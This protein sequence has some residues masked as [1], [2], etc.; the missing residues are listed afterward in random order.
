MLCVCECVFFGI[1]RCK[2]ILNNLSSGKIHVASRRYTTVPAPC[3]GGNN[4]KSRSV[5]LFRP[6]MLTP[7]HIMQ[8]QTFNRVELPIL[9]NTQNDQEMP[10]PSRKH[11]HSSV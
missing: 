11:K 5:L 9:L 8:A 1:Y 3:G 10:S 6:L 7:M 2:D 4:T